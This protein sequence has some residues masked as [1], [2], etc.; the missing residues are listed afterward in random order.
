ML[1]GSHIWVMTLARHVLSIFEG[2]KKTKL[3]AGQANDFIRPRDNLVFC[4]NWKLFKDLYQSNATLQAGV[5]SKN[6]DY[7]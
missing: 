2:K 3:S 7:F 6:A 5:H 4:N 1:H